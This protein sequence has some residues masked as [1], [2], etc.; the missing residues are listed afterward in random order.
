[1]KERLSQ[2]NCLWLSIIFLAFQTHVTA[3]SKVKIIDEKDEALIGVYINYNNVNSTTDIEGYWIYDQSLKKETVINFSYLGYQD[4]SISLESIESNEF[5]VKMLPD[6]RL[7]QE[8]TIVGRTNAREIDLPYNIISVKAEDI[9]NSSVQNS[10]DA[11]SLSGGAYIQKSQMGGGSPVLRGFEANKVLLVIDGVRMNNAIYRNGHLQNAITIDPLILKQA[12]VIFG[13]G[14]LMYGS[15][16][17]GGVVHYRTKSPLLN[18]DSQVKSKHKASALLRYNSSNHEKRIHFDHTYSTRHFGVLSS[19][20][21]S[22][23][24]DMRMG[25]KRS[26]KY[27][28]FGLRPDYVETI[29]G[30]DNVLNNPNPN[31]QLG[32]AY[33]QFDF[34][35]KY[36]YEVS[37]K[38]KSEL[39]IQYSTSSDIPRYDNL[40]ERQNGELRYAEWY[41][42]PQNRL[43]ISPKLTFKS[44]SALFDKMFIISSFQK[45]DESR[46]SRNL[47]APSRETQQEDV[48]VFGLT[49]DFNKRLNPNQKLIYGFDYH[50]NDVQSMA[51]NEDINNVLQTELTLSRYPSG[52]S[53]LNNAG[54]FIQHNLQNRD[55]TL[56]WITGLRYTQQQVN[57]QYNTND[58]FE[59][60]DYFYSGVTSNNSAL[61]G[62]TGINYQKNN[63]YLKTSIG[64]AFR[65]P[66]VDDLAKIRV[67]RNEIT[68]PNPNLSSEK[69]I[70]TELTLGYKSTQFSA[71]ITGYYTLLKD[72]IIRENFALP[73]G[74]EIFVSRGDTLNVTANINAS[75]GSIKG[76]S[77]NML[78]QINTSLEFKSSL[79]IQ[80]GISKDANGTESPLGHIPPS[81]GENTLSYTFRKAT[82]Q[83]SHQFNSFKRIEN[84]GG[85]VDNPDL[86]TIDGSPSWNLFN[87]S[88]TIEFNSHFILNA[89]INNLT[90]LHY[91]PFA[92][93]LSGAGRHIVLSIR[94]FL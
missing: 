48:K 44:S 34:L 5:M 41:Y 76:L 84:F 2:F 59:W 24:S 29:N 6:A 38:I 72:A 32:T 35:Q 86:A 79:N 71:A 16:A 22:D 12:E 9:V 67:N 87:I 62:V 49:L 85:S 94:Y 17:L 57:L 69:V 11:L 75:S 83:F 73:N 46:I 64:N 81:F 56:I 4:Q 10:A 51:F 19:V 65:S 14:S 68:V 23:F 18:F 27:P 15:E 47:N 13:P 31:I 55:S 7:L 80:R 21:F 88:S 54:V 78:Y 43:L 66:N 1:M 40:A 28:Q 61:V 92:S 52:G 53:Q 26:D 36:V 89:S 77:F 82:F 39:N 33:N 93:G 3:Q 8:L 30:I 60:P 58:P 42:G 90:D 37:D 70:N 63:F 45:I 25:N 20:S 91:R 74:S 50:F